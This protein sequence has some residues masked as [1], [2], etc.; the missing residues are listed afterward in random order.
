MIKKPTGPVVN[1]VNGPPMTGTPRKLGP[2]QPG[3]IGYTGPLGATPWW[4]NPDPNAT[5]TPFGQSELNKAK[6]GQPIS[7]IS[8]VNSG[9]PGASGIDDSSWFASHPPPPPP[10]GG[11]KIISY[12]ATHQGGGPTSGS[13]PA[14][15]INT[16]QPNQSGAPPVPYASP[17]STP[18]IF[19]PVTGAVIPN[20]R[21]SL[22][23]GFIMPGFQGAS[24]PTPNIPLG[25]TMPPINPVNQNQYDPSNIL[26]T[27]FGI[28][29]TPTS[30]ALPP[31]NPAPNP[32]PGQ[33]PYGQVPGVSGIPPSQY[34]QTIQN[35]PGLGPGASD[36]LSKNIINELTG[37]LSPETLRNIQ[38]E[39]AR[40]GVR[41]GMPGS[42][43]IP[44]SL[45]FNRMLRNLALDTT[46]VQRQGG[47]DYL[48]ALTGIGS[49]QLNPALMAEIAQFNALLK[50]APDPK[51]AADRLAQDF[52]NA[53]N[54]NRQPQ[55]G[56]GFDWFI[57]PSSPQNGSGA[58]GFGPG[59]LGKYAPP[60]V[61][62]SPYSGL[63]PMSMTDDEF[64]QWMS[65]PLPGGYTASNTG[66]PEFDP[67][68]FNWTD[69]FA[70]SPGG[71]PVYDQSGG[72]GT[73]LTGD[74]FSNLLGVD[75]GA[76]DFYGP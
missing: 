30:G 13:L 41:S 29:A 1:F 36:Q 21:S 12:V 31:Y 65:Q 11:G 68:Q 61:A 45:G 69:P 72:W 15:N 3:E 73:D 49:Q 10:P 19:N 44:G 60:G 47:Q 16:T 43:A 71:Q 23:P 35:V 28:G 39:A 59:T 22:P 70:S 51:A 50:A 26:K 74:D 66:V 37:Q 32:M 63:D 27:L 25:G 4:Q 62:P 34:Q 7:G 9:L 18:G 33:G 55:G 67:S 5:L 38:D 54:R 20:G 52:F 17:Y 64:A 58:L 24:N 42:N 6:A 2:P 57:P 75:T 76:G 48:S 8:G 40:F 14:Y 46:L 56:G 53:Q